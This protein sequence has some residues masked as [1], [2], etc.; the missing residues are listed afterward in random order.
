MNNKDIC[1]EIYDL[2]RANLSSI[3]SYRDT[4]HL[5]ED[6]TFVSKGDLLCEEIIF[7]YL[8]DNLSNYS[9]ISEESSKTLNPADACEFVV[10]VDPIDGTENFV[11]GL[12]EWGVGIS[13]YRNMQHYQSMIALP[14]L[15]ICLCSGDKIEKK[16]N[17]RILGLSSYMTQA[18]FENL[19]TQYE[20]RIM[21]CCMYNMY[22]VIRGSYKQ[23]QNIKGCYSW[24]LLP[25]INIALEQGLDVEIDNKKYSGEFLEPNKKYQVKVVAN[26]S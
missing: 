15:G 20:Y 16:F 23:F 9:V 5:K 4:G 22:N 14:E 26:N 18:D 6:G 2:I 21:G 19:D 7:K 13:I 1:R 25:G 24:D 12:K 3:L 11:S 17:S 10:T 8:R